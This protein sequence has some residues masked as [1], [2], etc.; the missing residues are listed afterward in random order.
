M[1]ENIYLKSDSNI[2]SPDCRLKSARLSQPDSM[3]VKFD[4]FLKRHDSY[5]NKAPNSQLSH[6]SKISNNSDNISDDIACATEGAK[7]HRLSN[8]NNPAMKIKAFLLQDKNIYASNSGRKSEL[9]NDNGEKLQ[10]NFAVFE[11]NFKERVSL[12]SSRHSSGLDK[13]KNMV[14]RKGHSNDE[15]NSNFNNNMVNTNYFSIGVPVEGNSKFQLKQEDFKIKESDRIISDLPRAV[16]E[17]LKGQ[18]QNFR[19]ENSS[20]KYDIEIL[21]KQYSEN[22]NLLSK[23]KFNEIDMQR[24]LKGIKNSRNKL[25]SE[26]VIM[27]NE[28]DFLKVNLLKKFIY[29]HIV[30]T[31][32]F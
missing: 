1:K 19:K 9:R 27:C 22:I 23:N 20:L 26:K 15:I 21:M 28:L 5:V 2:P 6:R 13:L 16:I 32:C 17:D 12:K 25:I 14:F 18:L 10:M 24:E 4:K 30:N 3:K 31:N 8:Q 11:E 29:I 7:T